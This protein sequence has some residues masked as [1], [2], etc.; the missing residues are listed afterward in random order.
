MQCY[1]RSA[2]GSIGPS[3]AR[4]TGLADKA[5][6]SWYERWEH[7]MTVAKRKTETIQKPR[8]RRLATLDEMLDEALDETFPASDAVVLTLPSKTVRVRARTEK[9]A[10]RKAT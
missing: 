5:L 2:T 3:P 7:A 9:R 8:P 10:A 6:L 1:A 4:A